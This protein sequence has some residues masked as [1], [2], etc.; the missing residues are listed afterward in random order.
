ML[1]PV[2]FQSMPFL[3]SRGKSPSATREATVPGPSRPAGDC[4]CPRR[5]PAFTYRMVPGSMP[6]WL[7]R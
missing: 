3:T 7:T 5:C 2:F 6:A 1:R 4:R